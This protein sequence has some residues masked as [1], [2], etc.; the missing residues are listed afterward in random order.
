MNQKKNDT[1]VS[2]AALEVLSEIAKIHLDN[3]NIDEYKKATN[4][5]YDFIVIQC[6]KPP[7]LHSKDMHSTLV[8]AYQ[9]YSK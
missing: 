5:I 6:S 7:P 2:L 4:C 8:A 3:K 9:C 1:Q